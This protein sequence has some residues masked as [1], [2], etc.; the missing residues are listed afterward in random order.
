MPLPAAEAVEALG[1]AWAG[2]GQD[3]MGARGGQ[4]ADALAAA[5]LPGDVQWSDSGSMPFHG[6]GCSDKGLM[7]F[8]VGVSGTYPMR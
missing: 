8:D 7:G 4:M 1:A 2:A 3:T 6:F 5:M